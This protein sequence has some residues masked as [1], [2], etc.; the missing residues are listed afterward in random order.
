MAELDDSGHAY[1]DLTSADYAARFRSS[2]A[3]VHRK[4]ARVKAWLL[5]QETP[6]AT[7]LADGTRETDRLAPAGHWVVENP[8]GEQYAV[9]P[10][11]FEA[12]YDAT[13]EPGVFQAKGR[14]RV[15]ENTT[16]GPVRIDAPWGEPQYG[17]AD[18]RFACTV[19]ADGSLN[20]A[21]P[22]IIGRTE[23]AQ[24]YA[25]EPKRITSDRET[26]ELARLATILDHQA[27]ATGAL[28]HNKPGQPG[29]G[30]AVPTTATNRTPTRDD[31]TR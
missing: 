17:A 14:I 29:P 4:T 7:V 3:T 2:E 25:E 5:T 11:G 9:D 20:L 19:R 21:E 10:A 26:L 8:G 15:I 30:T 31:R 28:H 1:A 23:L 27:P 13:P 22:Y 18:C 24:T 16:G 6:L 12:R